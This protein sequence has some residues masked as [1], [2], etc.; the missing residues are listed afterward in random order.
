MLETKRLR[1]FSLDRNE[2]NYKYLTSVH[3][4]PFDFDSKIFGEK[5]NPADPDSFDRESIGSCMKKVAQQSSQNL[6]GNADAFLSSIAHDNDVLLWPGGKRAQS[7][8]FALTY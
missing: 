2:K 8:K 5:I 1:A 7:D 4:K 3:L 6:K